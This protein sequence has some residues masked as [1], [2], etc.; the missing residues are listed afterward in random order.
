MIDR[1]KG[2]MAVWLAKRFDG[3]YGV[4]TFG[5]QSVAQSVIKSSSKKH[6]QGF[7]SIPAGSLRALM[8]RLPV[9]PEDFVFVDYGCGKGR[10]LFIAAEQPFKQIIGIEYASDL[11]AIARRNIER[12]KGTFQVSIQCIEKDAIEYNPPRDEP[13]FIFLYS[14]FQG[15][16]LDQVLKTISQSYRDAPRDLIL[17]YARQASNLSPNHRPE[18]LENPS[19]VQ[20]GKTYSPI[21]I[22][23]LPAIEFTLF[24]VIGSD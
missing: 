23:A 17:C 3:T 7:G 13:C 15:P 19:F 8:R 11:A 9:A 2:L 4:D 18:I 12:T 21:D 24:R 22:G 16:V 5:Q 20:M 10:A 14:P 6:G 1:L